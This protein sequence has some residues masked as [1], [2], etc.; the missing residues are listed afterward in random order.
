MISLRASLTG[1]IT[2]LAVL[3]TSPAPAA[4]PFAL[5]ATV[6]GTT[7]AR[8][9]NNAEEALRGIS[10]GELQKLFSSYTDTSEVSATLNFRGLPMTFSFAGGS[11]TLRLQIPALDIDETFSGADRGDSIDEMVNS[12]QDGA[13]VF[14]DLQKKLA[15]VSAID[16]VAGNPQ[17]LMN[18]MVDETFADDAFDERLVMGRPYNPKGDAR[19]RPGKMRSVG[20]RQVQFDANG[21]EGNSTVIPLTYTASPS[22]RTM[23]KFGFP[24]AYWSADGASTFSLGARVAAQT[25][26]SRQ[27][28]LTPSAGWGATVSG[29]LGS[30][31]HLLNFALTSRYEM[32]LSRGMTLVFGN[33]AGYVR[34]MGLSIGEYDLDPKLANTYMKNGVQWESPTLHLLGRSGTVKTSYALTN[35]FGSD[36]YMNTLHEFGAAIGGGG[37]ADL[38]V[39]VEVKKT[40]ANDYNATSLGMNLRF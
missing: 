4:T 26:I 29:D 15:A 25:R 11:D 6:D 40:L 3:A 38:P 21:V 10:T 27:W 12:F 39:S 17:S 32:P 2:G 20:V 5:T 22:A 34:T 18:M 37:M 36:L 33:T 24:M 9:F 31:A 13:Q 16:P 35:Y 14:S 30:A 8:A 19:L 28:T 23:V 1:L 7:S